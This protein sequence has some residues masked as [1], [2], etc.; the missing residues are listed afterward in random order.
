MDKDM[1]LNIY[2]G[3]HGG[4]I[5]DTDHNRK[6]NIAWFKKFKKLT[7][8]IN[9]KCNFKNGT[10]KR[11]YSNMCCCE[12]CSRAVG[13]LYTILYSDI[14][15]YAKLY[16][17]KTGFWRTDG[18]VLPRELRSYT[19]LGFNC[20]NVTEHERELI[21]IIYA[22]DTYI[23]QYCKKYPITVCGG[24]YIRHRYPV[25]LREYLEFLLQRPD[26]EEYQWPNCTM[27][28]PI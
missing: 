1:F 14:Q 10:C 3:K 8:L 17:T 9:Y 15:T 18:C 11:G 7:S 21:N 28:N 24:R 12:A 23:D 20:G 5:S 13:Y 27:I 6:E 22:P 25:E 16:N 4:S 19:C 26:I 2:C